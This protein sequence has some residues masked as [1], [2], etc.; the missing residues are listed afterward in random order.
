MFVLT[1]TPRWWRSVG[2]HRVAVYVYIMLRCGRMAMGKYCSRVQLYYTLYRTNRLHFSPAS[3]FIFRKK[4]KRI[5]MFSISL[6]FF[7][8]NLSLYLCPCLWPL[9]FSFSV[10]ECRARAC[11]A[12]SL[13]I[14]KHR[15]RHLH[16][17]RRRR[18][19]RRFRWKS[20]VYTRYYDIILY[21]WKVS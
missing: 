4:K 2:R 11:V 17:R 21:T 16:H 7:R 1:H 6:K 10:S 3:S 18:C 13:L 5:A 8:Y 12:A 20:L 14:W 19:W 15:H 9:S